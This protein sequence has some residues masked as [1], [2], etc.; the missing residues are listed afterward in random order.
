M[1]GQQSL[2]TAALRPHRVT[3]VIVNVPSGADSNGDLYGSRAG[4]P[5]WRSSDPKVA[6][7]AL[8]ADTVNFASLIKARALAAMDTSTLIKA[9]AGIWR[10]RNDSGGKRS[11]T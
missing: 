4:Y 1:G 7:T 3:A 11:N 9:P 5:N 10:G 2:V 8:Y 6:E